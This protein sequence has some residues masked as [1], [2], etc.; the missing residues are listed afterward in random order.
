MDAERTNTDVTATPCGAAGS[1][2]NGPRQGPLLNVTTKEGY[3]QIIRQQSCRI[4]ELGTQVAQLKALVIQ[5]Q[6]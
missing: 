2:A 3:L 4:R 6:G 5:L 1:D